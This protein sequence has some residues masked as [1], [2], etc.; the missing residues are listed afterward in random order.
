MDTRDGEMRDFEC[1]HGLMAQR[2]AFWR[3]S[4]SAARVGF[5][6]F[7]REVLRWAFTP[8]GLMDHD[9]ILS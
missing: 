3:L 2:L 4:P 5:G 7:C 8:L 9:N 1:D 6:D